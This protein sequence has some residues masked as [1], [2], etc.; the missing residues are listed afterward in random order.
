MKTKTAISLAHNEYDLD[1]FCV[2]LMVTHQFVKCLTTENI[3]LK[4]KK[5]KEQKRNQKA[6]VLKEIRMRPFIEHDLNV[7]VKQAKEFLSEG[8]RI[9]VSIRF[10]GRKWPISM[11]VKS[12]RKLP[13]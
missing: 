3:A 5:E 11:S 9:K 8:D 7:R 12:I 4:S 1:L 6:S 2:N 10:R 13:K